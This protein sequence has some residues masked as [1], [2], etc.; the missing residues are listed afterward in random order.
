MFEG[1]WKADDVQ[2]SWCP[3]SFSR[4]GNRSTS[5]T[6]ELREEYSECFMNEGCVTWQW[7]IVRVDF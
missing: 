4:C 2:R 5:H 7:K 6:R 3:I 1:S